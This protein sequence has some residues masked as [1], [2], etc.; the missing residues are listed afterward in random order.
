MTDHQAE[1]DRLAD[2][3]QASIDRTNATIEEMKRRLADWWERYPPA[4]A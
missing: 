4:D 2:D 1:L 3:I